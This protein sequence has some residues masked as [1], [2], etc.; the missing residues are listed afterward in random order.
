MDLRGIFRYIGIFH[1]IDADVVGIIT[2]RPSIG[3]IVTE[4]KPAAA[5][6]G[7]RSG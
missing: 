4:G 2:R 1:R 7:Y 5:F 6:Q 3:H